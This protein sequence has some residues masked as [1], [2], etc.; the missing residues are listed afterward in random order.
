VPDANRILVVTRHYA[1]EP[2]GSAPVVQEAA[3]WLAAQ[4]DAVEVVTVWP[5]YPHPFIFDGY[6]KGER[7]DAI[8]KAVHVRRWPTWPVKGRKL[9]SR[10]G[11][12][13]R[14]MMQ[15]LAARVTGRIRPSRHVLSLCPS[16]L[17]VLGALPLRARG[18]RHVVMV[19]DIQSGLGSAIEGGGALMAIL[20]KVEAWTLNRADQIVVLSPAM[21]QALRR[22]GVRTPALIVPPHIDTCAITPQPAPEGA[23][24]T[25]M[26]SGNLGQKQGLDQLIDLAALLKADAPHVRILVRGEGSVKARLV[27]RAAEM[28]HSN[29]VFEPLVD[30]AQ[31][32]RSL[33]EGDVH[34]VPQLAGGREFAMPS[35]AFAIMAAGRPFI[36][37]ADPDSPMAA[38][39]HA[40]GAGICVPCE[41]P[42][43]FADAALALLADPERRAA[44]G[45]AGRAHVTTEVDTQVVMRKIRQCLVGDGLTL[46]DQS[47][48]CSASISATS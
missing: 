3:E 13:L 19:H 16:I 2:T 28:G 24:P 33:A 42:R 10:F 44:M 27:E 46:K 17:T 43:A 35:K 8:E 18:G 25:L 41:N 48:P 15:L 31:I 23:P 12:E 7:D 20:Q 32:A 4:G 22:I 6:A 45:V 11:P 38:L 14:F 34:L 29:I 30:K 39:T 47:A 1:P 36:A 9:L 5:N 21:E 26:Y 40:L 37:T